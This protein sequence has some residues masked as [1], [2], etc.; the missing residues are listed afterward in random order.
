MANQENFYQYSAITQPDIIRLI[1]LQPSEHLEA[2]LCCSL[3][4]ASLKGCDN[5]VVEHVA[6]S[7][8]WGNA[9]LK[10]SILVDGKHL[11]ITHSLEQALRHVRDPR[12]VLRVWADGICINQKDVEDR[13]TQVAAMGTIY[14]TA[15]HTIIFLGPSYARH[16]HILDTITETNFD[17]LVMLEGLPDHILDYP[18][19]SRVW[20]LQELVLSPDPWVQIGRGRARWEHFRRCIAITDPETQSSRERLLNSMGHIRANWHARRYDN[21]A[22]GTR[23]T[24]LDILKARR[25]LGV[26]DPRDMAYAHLGM[27]EP[28]A[29]SD[30]IINYSKSKAQV[31]E[32]VARYIYGVTL[33]F[34]ILALVENVDLDTRQGLPTWV[35]DWSV[36]SESESIQARH[37]LSTIG[38]FSQ[39]QKLCEE[40]WN[41]PSVLIVQG[42]LAGTVLHIPPQTQIPNLPGE[43][44]V[45]DRDFDSAIMNW[46]L[47]PGNRELIK[48]ILATT[49]QPD[50]EYYKYQPAWLNR[51]KARS[52]NSEAQNPSNSE[53]L[54]SISTLLMQ[55]PL[56]TRKH[57]ERHSHSPNIVTVAGDLCQTIEEFLFNIS[58]RLTADE[59]I[60]FTLGQHCDTIRFLPSQV[61]VGDLL[62]Y[63]RCHADVF[64]FRPDEPNDVFSHDSMSQKP[65]FSMP[66]D[67]RRLSKS[68]IRCRFVTHIPMSSYEKRRVKL[69]RRSFKSRL[70]TE[71]TA[72]LAIH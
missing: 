43:G 68:E 11:E 51:L 9:S 70:G 46:V 22:G 34:S 1:L 63:D 3:I 31:Y 69:L 12:R 6:L 24:L 71:L 56:A 66:A 4:D 42:R 53:H 57:L 32:D 39:Y 55:L 35:P 59:I 30:I 16:D 28:S 47:H 33:G 65:Q 18:W 7:Y 29:R 61:C 52:K 38:F 49:M 48:A 62:V 64:I 10:G 58:S 50:F 21:A 5:D 17:E 37:P 2:K 45:E 23:I 13:N 44:D 20:V 27:S 67:T 41:R 36:K 8:V 54:A 19:F 25:G 40:P 15:R 26:S 60:T 72:T 14:A